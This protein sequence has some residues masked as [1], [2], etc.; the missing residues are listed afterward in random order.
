MS[1]LPFTEPHHAPPRP[2]TLP[3]TLDGVTIQPYIYFFL[4]KPFSLQAPC[5]YMWF[6][7]FIFTEMS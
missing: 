3:R 5:I 4:S 2:T 7:C 6:I 1:F